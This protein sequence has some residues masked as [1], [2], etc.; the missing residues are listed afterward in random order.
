[1]AVVP[2]WRAL[3]Q[4][5]SRVEDIQVYPADAIPKVFRLLDEYI[6]KQQH[7][8]R[9]HF[10]WL[11]G[12][13]LASGSCQRN[14][15]VLPGPFLK[16]H[17]KVIDS[18]LENLLVLPHVTHLSLKN[19]WFTPHTFY[20]I[21]REMALKSLVSLELVT[22]SLSGPPIERT[23]PDLQNLINALQQNNGAPPNNGLLLTNGVLPNGILIQNPATIP[24]DST[25]PMVYPP[26]ALSWGHVIDML[27]PSTTIREYI[28]ERTRSPSTP[29]LRVKNKLKLRRLAF[30]SCGYVEVPDGRFVASWPFEGYN[31][32]TIERS[33]PPDYSRLNGDCRCVN[34]F[35][36]ANTDRHLGRV[37][38]GMPRAEM[39]TLRQVFGF[40][41]GW[42]G[43]HGGDD[44]GDGDS[45]GGGEGSGE[46]SGDAHMLFGKAAFDGAQRDG[47]QAPGRGRFTGI[48]ER[49]TEEMTPVERYAGIFYPKEE[50]EEG[51]G[52]DRRQNA[53]GVVVSRLTEILDTRPYDGDYDDGGGTLEA[54]VKRLEMT[55]YYRALNESAGLDGLE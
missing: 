34:F 11:C 9:L 43:A 37:V 50:K 49:Q 23:N 41:F 40:R 6:G 53:D 46:G 4:C 45:D 2:D 38:G 32:S 8:K 20:R 47:T 22:V 30:K 28:H 18:R 52:E 26:F 48:I 7:I 44:D 39:D 15:N 55:A 17:R 31:R 25:Q 29:A 13:E 21:V 19:C 5:G 24:A 54:L 36:Q 14:Q 16:N 33:L 51:D 35:M 12:G 1:M 3:T 10:E 42:R 27:S